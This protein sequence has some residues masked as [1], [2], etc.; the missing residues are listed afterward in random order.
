LDLVLVETDAI[1]L[2]IKVGKT[3]QGMM[4][5]IKCFG[6]FLE[7]LSELVEFR[8]IRKYGGVDEKGRFRFSRQAGL[9]G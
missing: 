7:C 4:K 3:H 9:S 6:I 8:I 1:N 5:L 2:Q